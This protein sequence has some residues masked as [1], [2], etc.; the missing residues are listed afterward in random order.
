MVSL[1]AVI[2]LEKIVK[3]RVNSEYRYLVR[4]YFRAA[5]SCLWFRAV[6]ENGDAVRPVFHV[7]DCRVGGN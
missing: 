3:K 5:I 1:I 6:C 7:S 2:S 4:V